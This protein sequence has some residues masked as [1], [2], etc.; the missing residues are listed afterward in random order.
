MLYKKTLS[1]LCQTD[2]ASVFLGSS[3]KQGL[4]TS[5]RLECHSQSGDQS[6]SWARDIILSG[7]SHFV[8]EVVC[9]VRV[10]VGFEQDRYPRKS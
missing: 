7:A 10:V 5:I 4:S 1:W 2:L 3:H 9:A 8:E 6:V